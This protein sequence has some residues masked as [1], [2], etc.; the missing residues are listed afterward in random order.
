MHLSVAQASS[1]FGVNERVQ[2]PEATHQSL[3]KAKSHKTDTQYL[4]KTRGQEA[5]G[6]VLSTR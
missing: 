5:L 3:H 2:A 6:K 1:S 4:R